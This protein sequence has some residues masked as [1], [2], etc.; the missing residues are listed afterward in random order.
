M[1]KSK[2]AVLTY[3]DNPAVDFG[4]RLCWKELYDR[5]TPEALKSCGAFHMTCTVSGQS[6]SWDARERDVM[7]ACEALGLVLA[8]GF[9]GVKREQSC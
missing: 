9:N 6:R 1:T 8:N 2:E 5:D 3:F 4:W 7:A